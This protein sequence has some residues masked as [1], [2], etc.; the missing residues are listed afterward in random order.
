MKV[1]HSSLAT[2]ARERAALWLAIDTEVAAYWTAQA[3][4]LEKLAAERQ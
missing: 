1:T 2:F 4:R 3:E